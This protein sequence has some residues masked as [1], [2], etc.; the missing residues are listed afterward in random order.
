MVLVKVC[1]GLDGNQGHQ[2]FSILLGTEVQ[3]YDARK[4]PGIWLE[5]YCH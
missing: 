3:V 4:Y 1:W 5:N 2:I